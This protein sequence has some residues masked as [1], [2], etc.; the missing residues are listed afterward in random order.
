M[1]PR[2]AADLLGA[3]YSS[4]RFHYKFYIVSAKRMRDN[5]ANKQSHFSLLAN[6]TLCTL[7]IDTLLLEIKCA[8][9]KGAR[10]HWVE[11]NHSQGSESVL[12]QYSQNG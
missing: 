2:P 1:A 7:R 12:C 10:V 8:A 9:S 6:S 11:K 5:P 3:Q 4:E